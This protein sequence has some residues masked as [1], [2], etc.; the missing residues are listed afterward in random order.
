MKHIMLIGNIDGKSVDLL[1]YAGK[2]CKDLNLKL[3]ILQITP[4][5]ESIFISSP[6]YYNKSGFIF[7][8]DDSVKKKELEA[9]VNEHTKNLIDSEWVSCKLVKGNIEHALETFI[10]TEK[11][12]LLLTSQALFK[13]NVG[14]N[15]AFKQVLLN[16]SE[17]PTLI[18]PEN[19]SYCRFEN[20]AYFSIF[21]KK[22]YENLN[23][24]TK[25][26]PVT[27]INLIHFSKEPD[28][29]SNEKWIKFLKS[30]IEHNLISYHR[31]DEKLLD[32][33]KRESNIL[34]PEYGCIALTT[35]K[36]TFWQRIFDPSTTLNLITKI[37]SPILI[38]KYKDVN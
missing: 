22:D 16:V 18:I 26:F 30:E 3:H 37:E 7:N 29:I 8:Q 6:Y 11:I 19:Q 13:N 35:R 21:M 10:N 34:T 5:N 32:F 2:F 27:P 23:W 4:S 33:I 17:S 38:F 28:S 24:L 36:R 25:S 9:F 1:R 31:K 14:D 15:D 20:M 12:D